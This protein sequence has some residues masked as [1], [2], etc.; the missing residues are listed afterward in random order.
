MALAVVAIAL[1]SRLAIPIP[2]T[3][4]PQTAQ[5]LAVL[6]TGVLLGARLGPLAVVAYIA[7]GIAGVPL[8]ADGASGVARLLG[9]S[10]GYLLGFVAA[11]AI[12]GWWVERGYAAAFPRALGGMTLA[13]VV[14]LVS[15]WVWLSMSIGAGRA[16]SAGVE[17][18]LLGA[19][20]KSA[21]A[22]LLALAVCAK[23]AA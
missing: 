14:V 1:A 22:A 6:A 19:V 5:T 20:V 11:A 16:F 23:R 4:V 10:G 15:G 13:H 2:G 18:F 17:P 12:A 8:F 21:L 3:D 9:P 7:L